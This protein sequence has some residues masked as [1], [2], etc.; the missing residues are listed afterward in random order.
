MN[1][2]L[3]YSQV[4]LGRFDNG[5]RAGGIIDTLHFI[6]L[7]LAIEALEKAD[8]MDSDTFT[9]LKTWFND[10][11]DFM[12]N[13]KL[14]KEEFN[15]VNN[16]G[17][18]WCVQATLYAKLADREDVM[19]ICR[20]RFKEDFIV[21]QLA[22][23]GTFP[24]ELARTKPY[25]YSLFIMDLLSILAYQL[26]T[27]EENLF[28]FKTKSGKSF[29]TGLDFIIPVTRD[30][31]LWPYHK[32]VEHFESYPTRQIYL[33]LTALVKNDQDLLDFWMSFDPDPKDIEVRRN[34]AMRQPVLWI[35]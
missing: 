10:Y 34:L 27:P 4:V 22:E 19:E 18:A 15:Q 24:E 30:K 12:V 21:N 35:R 1:P 28:E 6:E 14:G 23:D 29:Q 20:R 16:H 8:A 5:G 3:N 26:S 31:S 33:L 25:N 9:A 7:P 32:D 17:V 13:S 2:S 11:L